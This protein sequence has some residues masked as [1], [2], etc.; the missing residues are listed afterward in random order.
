MA[1]PVGI[2]VTRN[3]RQRETEGMGMVTGM[4]SALLA[5]ISGTRFM[6]N[7]NRPLIRGIAQKR[8]ANRMRSRRLALWIRSLLWVWLFMESLT[9]S[10]LKRH[11]SAQCF[12]RL[13]ELIIVCQ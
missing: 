8:D 5:T 9:V 3:P 10:R 13:H 7:Q 2:M 6:D 1:T 12:H 11:E 4:G